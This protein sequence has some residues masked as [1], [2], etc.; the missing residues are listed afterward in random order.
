MPI[1]YVAA[2]QSL[3]AGIWLIV[4]AMSTHPIRVA[5]VVPGLGSGGLERMVRDLAIELAARAYDPA[6]FCT[7]KLGQYAEDLRRA[8]IPVWDCGRRTLRV[9]P[10][11]LIKRL[12]RFAPDI[13]HAHGG[14]WQAA[15]TARMLLRATP[16]T[17]TEHGRNPDGPSWR[18]A[19]DRWSSRRTDRI[20]AV[21]HATAAELRRLLRLSM[22]PD[23]I[24]NG[25]EA[26]ASGGRAGGER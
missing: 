26:P 4:L 15:A 20:T 9:L 5:L 22:T 23:V 1:T 2:P 19:I 24:V 10:T 11:T 6:V 18:I 12:I 14:A 7:T 13:V 25:V 3:S 16:L 21:S 17:Y 8:R